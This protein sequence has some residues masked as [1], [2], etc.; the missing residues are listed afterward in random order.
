MFRIILFLVL[1]ALAASGA[2]W[3]AEQPGD[4]MLSWGGWRVETSLSVFALALGL[5]LVV[6]MLAWAIVRGLWRTPQRLKRE[7]ARAPS[8]ARPPCHYPWAAR[9]RPRR[10]R[11]RPRACRSRPAPRRARSAGAA[12]ACAI[13]AARRRPRG[14]A[15]R[16]PRHGGA[17]GHPAARPARAVHRGAARRRSRRRRDHRRRSAENRAGLDLGL[18]GRAWFSL[19]G[20]RLDRGA[21]DS[22]KQSR[23]RADRQGRLPAPARRAADGAGA[24]ARKVSTATC[25]ATA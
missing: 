6:A 20:G 8:G 2:T 5:V 18:A 24:R 22:R 21:V 14:R 3:V 16:L 4:V 25:R 7:S 13:R 11:G 15:P 10:F 17:R 1:I 19:R 12:A 23:L 9:H